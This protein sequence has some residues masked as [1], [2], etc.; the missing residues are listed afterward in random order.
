M[1]NQRLYVVLIA[2]LIGTGLA[3][4]FRKLIMAIAT[5][6]TKMSAKGRKWLMHDEGWENLAYKDT[7]GY[8]TIGV[9][10]LIDLKN[11]KHLLTATLTDAQV[12]A[13]F[14]KDLARFERAVSSAIDVP[15]KQHQFDALV[16]FAYNVGETGMK[17]SQLVKQIN[18][19]NIGQPT[20]KGFGNWKGKNNSHALR[21]VIES[22]LFHDGVYTERYPLSLLSYDAKQSLINNYLT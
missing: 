7:A 21:R 11:E 18:S 13:L 10:H 19:E 12:Q 17:N 3:L 16:S 14:E 1:K 9:G 6:P 2:V 8:W 4:I 20:K 22:K 15:I 5:N